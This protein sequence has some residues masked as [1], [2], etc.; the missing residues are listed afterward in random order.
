MVHRDVTPGNVMLDAG[1]TKVVDFGISALAGRATGSGR[2]P[3]RHSRR[4]L[5]RERLEGGQVSPATDVYAVGLLIC[6]TL[7]RQM[8]WHVGR[9]GRPAARAP[10][11]EPEPLE[12]DARCRRR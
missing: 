4:T 7:S 9:P 10:Y 11:T 2:Q 5:A 3:A 8:P 12:A 1:G 6:R